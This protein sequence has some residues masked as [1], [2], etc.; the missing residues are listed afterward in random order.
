[1]PVY[2]ADEPIFCVAKG[3]GCVLEMM[4]E[5]TDNFVSW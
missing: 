4:S 3:T 5:G 2:V 1:V